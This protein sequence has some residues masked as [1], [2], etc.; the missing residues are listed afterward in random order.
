MSAATRPALPNAPITAAGVGA[1]TAVCAAPAAIAEAAA[2]R[3]AVAVAAGTAADAK[4]TCALRAAASLHAARAR[5]RQRRRH[6]RRC[7][8]C[9]GRCRLLSAHHRAG[10]DAA[11]RPSALWALSLSTTL[12]LPGASAGA[13]SAGAEGCSGVALIAPSLL[14]LAHLSLASTDTLALRAAPQADTEAKVSGVRQA[15]SSR[16]DRFVFVRGSERAL[17]DS[18]RRAILT[19][20]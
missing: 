14:C 15:G 13:G 3:A 6:R 5:R 18:W 12:S 17:L 8:R 11:P 2:A 4:A 19:V 7:S 20:P 1:A 10:R 9:S 16:L